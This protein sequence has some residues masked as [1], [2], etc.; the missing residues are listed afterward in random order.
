MGVDALSL[1]RCENVLCVLGLPKMVTYTFSLANDY[2][3]A[4]LKCIH[5]SSK[6]LSILIGHNE[7]WLGLYAC[8]QFKLSSRTRGSFQ[9]VSLSDWGETNSILSDISHEQHVKMA[10]CCPLPRGNIRRNQKRFFWPFAENSFIVLIGQMEANKH[11]QQ[12]I[13]P[14]LDKPAST[15]STWVSLPLDSIQIY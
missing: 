9:L 4:Y 10:N 5:Y 2:R 6:S 11:G 3:F 8:W 1:A 14:G 13:S 15:T 7:K 12:P